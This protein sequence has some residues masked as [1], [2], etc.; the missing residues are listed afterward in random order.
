VVVPNQLHYPYYLDRYY[1]ELYFLALVVQ[2]LQVALPFLERLER[3][4]MEM[5]PIPQK[6]FQLLVLID[7]L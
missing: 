4:L 3:Q 6:A 1:F 7:R 2:V 5:D